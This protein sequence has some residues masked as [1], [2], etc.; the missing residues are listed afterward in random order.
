[1]EFGGLGLGVQDSGFRVSR[2][3]G[4]VIS[5]SWRY[6]VGQ[7]VTLFSLGD[8]CQIPNIFPKVKVV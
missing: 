1:M 8:L 2:V 6:L 3:C 4:P 7:D 5:A